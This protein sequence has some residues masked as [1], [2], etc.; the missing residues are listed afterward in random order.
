MEKT[1]DVK[2]MTPEDLLKV[3]FVEEENV[4]H[5]VSLCTV[6]SWTSGGPVIER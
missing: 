5:D 4:T 1:F 3:G 6:C 2:V